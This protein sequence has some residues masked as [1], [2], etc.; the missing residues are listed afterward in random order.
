MKFYGDQKKV[1]LLWEEKGI[2]SQAMF[3]S[4]CISASNEQQKMAAV[5]LRVDLELTHAEL[6]PVQSEHQLRAT[7]PALCCCAHAN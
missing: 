6:A 1:H 7:R 3:C 4:E 5:R 2:F